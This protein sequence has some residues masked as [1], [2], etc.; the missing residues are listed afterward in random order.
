MTWVATV[1][2]GTGAAPM[3]PRNIA[4]GLVE[5][6]VTTS[7]HVL[8][9]AVEQLRARISGGCCDTPPIRLGIAL[10]TNDI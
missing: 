6:P 7:D 2:P 9:S 4:G 10:E 3:L 8:V 1:E 5:R